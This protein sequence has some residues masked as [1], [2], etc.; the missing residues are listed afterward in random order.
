MAT[1]KPFR[2]YRPTPDKVHLVASRSYISYSKKEL[3]RKLD[4]NPYSF[5]HVINP[6][7]QNKKNKQSPSKSHNQKV[8]ER[9][10]S[11]VKEEIL[12][13]DNE[14]NFYIYRQIKEGRTYTGIIGCASVV[15]YEN[16]VIK[17]HEATIT[18]KEV[19][20]KNYLKDVGMNAEPVCF[21]YPNKNSIDKSVEEL[22]C[23]RPDYDFTTTN[24]VRHSFWK[25]NDREK[26]LKIEAEF[27]KIPYLYIADGHHRSASSYLL[28]KE[29]RSKRNG[30]DKS[31]YNYFMGIFIPESELKI[32]EF[33]RLVSDLGTLTNAELL[34]GI[35]E[36]FTITEH[37]ENVFKPSAIH[38]IGMYLDKKWYC[39]KP[40]PKSFDE[41][42]PVEN[43]D[44][45]IL[46]NNLLA[47]ILG[48]VDLKTDKRISFMGGM[49]K[50]QSLMHAVDSGKQ[51]LAFTHYPIS[52]EQ[53][54]EIADA[55]LIMPP[56]S[57]WIEPKL[58]SG[59]TI[60]SLLD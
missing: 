36:K 15:D 16:N 56:K 38:E 28:S 47:P 54:K 60:Y 17:K 59:L 31:A 20:F 34:K 8:K 45:S 12:L 18:K 48:I 7:H 4:E 37:A 3:E 22:T 21:T 11:F 26:V 40:K 9:F 30:D 33:N 1:V 42:H 23:N 27:Q 13:R 35:E 6:E 53:L 19:K 58:R 44:V 2:A 43:L 50:I 52:M 29:L 57:T 49:E 41:N 55:N 5:L 46:S 32:Y 25:V 24:K 14:N 10:E 51:K 39:L